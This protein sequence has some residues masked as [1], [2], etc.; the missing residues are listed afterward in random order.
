M[1]KI[2]LAA[3]YGGEEFAV[4]LP[5][6]N[7]ENARTV[8]EKIRYLV[9]KYHFAYQESQPNNNITISVGVSSYPS[10]GKTFEDIVAC[11]DK[12]LYLAKAKGKNTVVD[13]GGC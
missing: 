9:E 1:R 13:E 7:I 12:R 11:A 5:N 2:D 8:A 10:S 3:R 4:I 6:T